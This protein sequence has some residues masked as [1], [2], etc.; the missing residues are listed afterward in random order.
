MQ[1]RIYYYTWDKERRKFSKH[2]IDEGTVGTG[3]QIRTADLNQD[4]RPDIA[5][6]GKSGTYV[7]INQGR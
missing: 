7:L 3:L 5:V 2:V 6:A 1:G 4:G